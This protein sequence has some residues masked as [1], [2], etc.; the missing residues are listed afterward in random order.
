MLIYDEIGKILDVDTPDSSLAWNKQKIIR[1]HVFDMLNKTQGMFDWLNLPK[2]IPQRNLELMLQSFGVVAFTK[3]NDDYY[4]F[5]GGL[6]GEPDVYYE[7]T[8]FTVANPYLN[9]NAQLKIGEECVLIRN[10]A[11]MQGL[12]PINNRYARMLCENEISLILKDINYRLENLISATDDATAESAKVMLQDLILGKLGI[13]SESQF[14]E[15]LKVV[16]S[17]RSGQSIKDLIEYEQYINATWL[18][19][20][21]I[22]ANF[23]MKRERIQEDEAN[24]NKDALLTLPENM[25]E[26]RRI[27]VEQINEMYGLDISVN[28]ASAWLKEEIHQS[29]TGVDF[30]GDNDSNVNEDV[31]NVDNFVDN[32]D[33]INDVVE[34]SQ[35]EG[36][37]E[38][39]NFK[40][41]ENVFKTQEDIKDVESI[42]GLTEAIE[43][44]TESIIESEV[45]KE[46]DSE[47]ND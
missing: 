15:G 41:N 38:N 34:F 16:P 32:T 21:G 20:L 39:E 5:F 1:N 43:E 19:K 4:A 3:V 26:S 11:T 40:E 24:Q 8:I 42:E 18:N 35:N 30:D 13:I 46:Y 29:I 31:D 28:F 37:V 33:I 6:G 12:L 10:D 9:Y 2:T 22:D 14:F 44:L 47:N 27:A 45:M 23:N 36:N 25:L 7:P 17:G